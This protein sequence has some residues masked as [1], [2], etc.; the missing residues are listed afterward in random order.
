MI[1]RFFRFFDSQNT[2]FRHAGRL[3]RFFHDDVQHVIVLER[4]G[5][6]QISVVL[7]QQVGAILRM[8]QFIEL[9]RNKIFG[10]DGAVCVQ[11]KRALGIFYQPVKNR[12]QFLQVFNRR[13]L[14][15]LA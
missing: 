1:S 2:D 14:G 4:R 6:N 3:G 10:K 8:K 5:K 12:F 7:L 15:V 9:T 13:D 11:G